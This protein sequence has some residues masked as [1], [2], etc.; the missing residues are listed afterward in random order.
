MRIRVRVRVRVRGRVIGRVRV[1]GF[2][3]YQYFSASTIDYLQPLSNRF[4]RIKIS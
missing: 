4:N 1:K 3:I 2:L